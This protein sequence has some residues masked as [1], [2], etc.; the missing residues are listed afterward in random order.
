MLLFISQWGI[1]IMASDPL[2]NLAGSISNL[3]GTTAESLKKIEES[4]AGLQAARAGLAKAHDQLDALKTRDRAAEEFQMARDCVIDSAP[5]YIRGEIDESKFKAKVQANFKVAS[6]T[7]EEALKIWEELTTTF[8]QYSQK[9]QTYYALFEQADS[10]GEN[11]KRRES[12]KKER[13]EKIKEVAR[14]KAERQA[15]Q[16]RVRQSDEFWKSC[17]TYGITAIPIAAVVFTL[18]LL[19]KPSHKNVQKKIRG[20]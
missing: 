2:G 20:R 1:S 4:H 5:M 13:E 12:Q 18:W 7:R 10:T 17:L 6:I 16:E 14:E 3:C 15:E 9:L 8:P 11:S 19:Y